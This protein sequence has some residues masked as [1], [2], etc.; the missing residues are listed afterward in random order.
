MLHPEAI[1]LNTSISKCTWRGM[2]TRVC[3]DHAAAKTSKSGNN[4]AELN[5]TSRERT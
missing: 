5:S 2:E 1:A 4:S 3:E